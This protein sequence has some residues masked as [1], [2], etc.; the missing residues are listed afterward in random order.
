MFSQNPNSNQPSTDDDAVSLLQCPLDLQAFHQYH[1][2]QPIGFQHLKEIEEHVQNNCNKYSHPRQLK[3]L[4]FENPTLYHVIDD[5]D[6]DGYQHCIKGSISPLHK[7]CF[8]GELESVRHIIENWKVDVNFA[9]SYHPNYV[10]ETNIGEATPLFIAASMGHLEVVRYLVEEA[11]AD[12]SAKTSLASY[13]RLN[14]RTPLY[15]AFTLNGLISEIPLRGESLV[16]EREKRSAIVRILLKVGADLSANTMGF[17]DGYPV[18]MSELFGI[19]SLSALID[20]GLNLNH[21]TPNDKGGLTM[22]NYFAG[23]ERDCHTQA[24]VLDIVKLLLDRGADPHLKS[25]VGSTMMGLTTIMSAVYYCNEAVLNFLLGRSEISRME[26]IDAL[27]LAGAINLRRGVHNLKDKAFE[28]WRKSLQLRLIKTDGSGPMVKTRNKIQKSGRIR[29]WMTAEELERVIKNPSEHLTQS[30]LVGLR[31]LSNTSWFA[32]KWFIQPV[33]SKP[34]HQHFIPI[35][36]GLTTHQ[37]LNMLWLILGTLQGYDAREEGLWPVTLKFVEDLIETLLELRRKNV[38]PFMNGETI[39]TSLG[40]IL[41]TDQFHVTNRESVGNYYINTYMK[42]ML[43]LIK[44]LVGL[45]WMLDGENMTILSVL[46]RR[47]QRRGGHDN[48]QRRSD[49]SLLQM[50]CDDSQ[51]FPDGDRL[52]TIRLILAAGCNPNAAD[53]DGNTPLHYLAQSKS[54]WIDSAARLLLDAGAYPDRRNKKRQT[55]ADVWVES[56][57]ETRKRNRSGDQRDTEKSDVP[58]WFRDDT[59]PKLFCLSRRVIRSQRVAYFFDIP[60]SIHP[61]LEMQHEWLG[62]L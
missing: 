33:Y 15:G 6:G 10:G 35:Y 27:E 23:Q 26:K 60:P 19:S 13:D 62:N 28:Y 8:Y 2:E 24:E 12:V 38:Y 44:M 18:W 61:F 36:C 50:A 46:I 49:A 16:E 40:L 54:S 53:F 30:L 17:L 25:G 5:K 42:S 51:Y 32:L 1:G 37:K 57:P 9:S 56:H 58:G 31:I 55:A 39:K 21:R 48:Y 34:L 14:G 45:P 22:M 3:D 4:V 20:R 43:D 52:P 11:G 7:A 41:A 59:V 29:E 47:D